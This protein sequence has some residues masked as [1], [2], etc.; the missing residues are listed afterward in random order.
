[1]WN[2]PFPPGQGNPGVQMCPT[3]PD[4]M[5][6]RFRLIL[7][8]TRIGVGVFSIDPLEKLLGSSIE[9]I[10][11]PAMLGPVFRRPSM[12]GPA[13]NVYPLG[14]PAGEGVSL[15]LGAYGDL[16]FF[17]DGSILRITVPWQVG[18]WVRQSLGTVVIRGP[19]QA[20]SIDRASWVANLWLQLQP[21]M[22]LALTV[23]GLGEVG[24]EAG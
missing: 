15:Q 9:H 23:P 19:E 4:N 24:I 6:L 17:N 11:Q 20:H 13:V 5:P 8:I 12:A 1:M 16:G 3:A 18:G 22:G 14:L 7:P 10:L 2:N 21:G